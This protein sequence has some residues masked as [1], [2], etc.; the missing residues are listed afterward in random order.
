MAEIVSGLLFLIVIA[1]IALIVTVVAMAGF[2]GVGALFARYTELTIFQATLMAVPIGMVVFYLLGRISNL[3]AT[4]YEQDEWD[5]WD[6]FDEELEFED[7]SPEERQ[8][9][10]ESLVE[11]LREEYGVEDI[12]IQ[13]KP[14][15]GRRRRKEQ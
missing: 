1:A 12:M 9:A 15:Q 8:R 6:E 5:E 10:L 14:S 13:P 4:P 2:V 11:Y 3:P 7:L